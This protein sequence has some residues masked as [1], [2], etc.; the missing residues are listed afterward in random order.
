[1]TQIVELQRKVA[2]LETEN[3]ELKESLSKAV[4]LS[5]R[6][7]VFIRTDKLSN[8]GTRLSNEIVEK[9]SEIHGKLKITG[10]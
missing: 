7:F 4:I 2:A 3:S 10:S 6:I 5:Q 1:L 9:F 8:E